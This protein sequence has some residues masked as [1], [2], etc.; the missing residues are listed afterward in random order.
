[1]ANSARPGTGER[2]WRECLLLVPGLE[3]RG[4]LR[5]RRFACGKV[6]A[7]RGDRDAGQREHG[8]RAGIEDELRRDTAEETRAQVGADEAQHRKRQ[9]V[10]RRESDQR[11][12]DAD[13]RAFRH[14]QRREA[15]A[16]DAECPQQRELRPALHH[17][18]RLGREHEQ[19][20]GEQRHQR[21]HVEVDPITA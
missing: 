15:R 17:R 21:E 8:G 11:A 4:R 2:K 6:A 19:A 12:R 14:Q 9:C 13:Q 1:V 18:Q 5:A 3:R 16:R 20:P 7:E 10:T